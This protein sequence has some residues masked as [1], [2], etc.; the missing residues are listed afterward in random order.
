MRR[1]LTCV[2]RW[3]GLA[4]AARVKLNRERLEHFLH[5]GMVNSE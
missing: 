4:P 5:V 3:M 2:W 1:N